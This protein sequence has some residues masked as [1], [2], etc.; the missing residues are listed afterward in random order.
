MARRKLVLGRGIGDEGLGVDTRSVPVE[1]IDPSPFQPRLEISEEE[2]TEL[3]DSIKQHGLLQPI[4]VRRKGRRFEV[5]AGERRLRAAKLA[6]LQR[7]PVVVKDVS[8]RDAAVLALV[9]N[10]QR[11]DLSFWERASAIRRLH[12]EVG[13]TEEEIGRL[14]GI[15]KSHVSNYL[16]V[17][18]LPADV[19]EKLRACKGVTLKHIKA[20]LRLKDSPGWLR[21]FVDRISSET[22]SARRLEE[23]VDSALGSGGREKKVERVSTAENVARSEEVSRLKRLI[24]GVFPYP[25]RV[26]RVKS[27]W[28]V[29][30]IFPNEEDA[31]KFFS[32]VHGD[33]F[34]DKGD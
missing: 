7:V 13:L 3:A 5:I 24:R 30:L 33:W 17:F 31:R 25:F 1:L 4:V 14:L 20:L 22:I 11:K 9:E 19:L 34:E 15:S 29:T 26:K 21:E 27:G 18:S 23:L 32:S 12:D 28:S 6:G 8:D 2:L 16:R 10:L